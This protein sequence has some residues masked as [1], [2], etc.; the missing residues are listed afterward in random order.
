MT[1][2]RGD[3]WF[4]ASCIEFYKDDKGMSGRQAYDY[5]RKNNAVDFII[6]RWEG[7]HTTSPRYV[8][9]SIDEFIGSQAM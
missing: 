7:L 1:A 9:D 5:L 2:P 3:I 8:V 6:S 4:L